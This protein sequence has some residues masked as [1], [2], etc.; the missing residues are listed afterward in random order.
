MTAGKAIEALLEEGRLFPPPRE[1]AEQANVRDPKV[2]DESKRDFLSFWAGR[3]EQL[4]WY[5]KWGK[6]L[7]DGNPPFFQWFVGGKLNAS[8]N[9]LDRHLEGPRRN[10]AAIIWEGEPGDVLV[11]TYQMLYREVCRVAN[12]LKAM[13]VRKGDVVTIYLPMIP[14]L[15][16]AMLAC[17]RMGAIHSVVFAGF[18]AE[19][20]ATR[21]EDAE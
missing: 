21:M 5:E 10:K 3:A 18:S 14:E 11:Y 12:G 2:Y 17:A 7:E 16:I 13:G 4:H 9:C 1:F 20:L 15:P 8:Y 6:V 19:A